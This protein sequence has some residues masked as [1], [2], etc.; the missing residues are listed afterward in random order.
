MGRGQTIGKREELFQTVLLHLL[1]IK[2][3]RKIKL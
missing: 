1:Y 3:E 2:Y